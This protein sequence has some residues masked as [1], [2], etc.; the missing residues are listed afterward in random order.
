MVWWGRWDLNPRPSPPEHTPPSSLVKKFVGRLRRAVNEEVVNRELQIYRNYLI[1]IGRSKKTI[2][3]HCSYLKRYLLSG[4]PLNVEGVSAWLSSLHGYARVHAVRALRHYF[5]LK[6]RK[7]LLEAIKAR[8]PSE[9]SKGYCPT[10][11]EV[12]DVA[13]EIDWLP[14]KAYYVLLAESGLRPGEVLSLKLTKIDLSTRISDLRV[15]G[16]DVKCRV[17]AP[18]R[19]GPSKR[20][21]CSFYSSEDLILKYV[22]ASSVKDRLFPYKSR[23]LRQAIYQAMDRAI[24]HRFELYALRRFWA[25]E[26]HRRGMNPLTI[27]LL[28]GRKPKLYRIMIDHYLKLTVEDLRKEYDQANLRI[29]GN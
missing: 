6:G 28:Q 29:T 10:L 8:R 14:A 5:R 4:L 23:R 16:I 3:S 13:S 18:L 7:D 27:D 19:S 25:T 26:M 22:E 21:F 2:I 9:E 20:A 11:S 15:Q 17:L 12:I 1:S 24:G